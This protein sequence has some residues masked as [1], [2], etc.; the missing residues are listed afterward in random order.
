VPP[1]LTT[2][3][4]L[5]HLHGAW[6][7]ATLP[8]PTPAGLVAHLREA[9]EALAAGRE[10][11]EAAGCLLLLLGHAHAR[12]CSLW[13]AAVARCAADLTRPWGASDADGVVHHERED[14][15]GGGEGAPGGLILGTGRRPRRRASAGRRGR[16]EGP[17]R[18]VVA[19]RSELRLPACG[20]RRGPAP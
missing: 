3:D 12:G 7:M 8:S 9:V 2:L 13:D 19:E 14:G 4:D 10:P 1:R 6:S 18:P 17:R 20:R 11:E 16:E 15:R 5:Q